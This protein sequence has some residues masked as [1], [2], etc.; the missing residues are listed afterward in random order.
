[1]R[2]KLTVPHLIALPPLPLCPLSPAPPGPSPSI[3]PPALSGHRTFRP[4]MSYLD[5]ESKIHVPSLERV[6][7][8]REDLPR[9]AATLPLHFSPPLTSDFFC[10][11]SFLRAQ[12]SPASLSFGSRET[13][14]K[15][16]A[17]KSLV[18]NLNKFPVLSFS[19]FFSLFSCLPLLPP[20]P[21]PPPPGS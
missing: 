7:N 12:T 20:P 1:M 10:L 6:K 3:Y 11:A 18:T 5:A 9:L 2:R 8:V 14:K 13:R 16:R 17:K 21:S 19:F 4:E 15:A